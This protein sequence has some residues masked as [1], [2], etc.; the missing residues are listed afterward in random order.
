MWLFGGINTTNAIYIFQTIVEQDLEVQKRDASVLHCLH[1]A[2]DRARHDEIIIQQTQFK[3]DGKDLQM[4]KNMYWEQ[5]VTMPVVEE[6]SL[7]K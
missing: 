2:F 4:I 6:I 3:I 7:L 5:T 1:K